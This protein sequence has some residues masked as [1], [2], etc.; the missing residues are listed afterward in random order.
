MRIV[1]LFLVN[2]IYRKYLCIKSIHDENHQRHS[3]SK[4]HTRP[5][6]GISEC[7][8]LLLFSF[9]IKYTGD[10]YCHSMNHFI[11]C[12]TRFCSQFANQYLLFKISLLQYY[13]FAWLNR[14]TD[15][16]KALS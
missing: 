7:C 6:V 11:T 2:S 4:C 13:L 14:N 16:S 1:E 5:Q 10:S 12:K 3:T 8:P 15:F 9:S